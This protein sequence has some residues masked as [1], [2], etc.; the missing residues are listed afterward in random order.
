M[1]ANLLIKD[2]RPWGESEPR[3]LAIVGGRYVA[4][5][6]AD[7]S[8]AT[9]I[10]AGGR[11][12]IPGFIDPHIH[13]DKVLIGGDVALNETGVLTEGIELGWERKRA[14]TVDD[15]AERARRVITSAIANGVTRLRT[16]VDVDTIG[17]LTP[18]E[19][20]LETRRRFER[21]IDIQLI[22]F[23]QEGILRDPGT[24]ELM[25]EAMHMGTDVVGGMPFNEESPADSMEHIRIAFEIARAAD[26]D[27]DMHVDETDDPNARTLEMLA[28]ATIENGWQGRVTAGHTCALAAYPDDYAEQVMAMVK[29][30]GIH[31]ITNP[32]TNLMVQGRLDGQPKRRGITRVKELLARDINVSFGQ[33]NV[34]DAFY[35]FGRADPLEIA[36]LIAH[37]AH[38]SQPDEIETVFAMPTVNAARVLR[39]DGYGTKPGCEGD[40]VV[41]D[42]ESAVDAITKQADCAYVIK[43]GEVLAETSSTTTMYW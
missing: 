27:V 16:H 1:T 30:A 18:I 15:I 4:P 3:D 20:L 26:A 42:A 6:E 8:D 32:A 38:M 34:R 17:G 22:A 33:D 29:E 19:G 31:M 12:C 28:R 21:A 14:Y 5:D 13:L 11:L 25:R 43:R 10:D 40:L 23:P 9:V 2:A 35:P 36:L 24:A 39:V 7:G 37:A 41:L